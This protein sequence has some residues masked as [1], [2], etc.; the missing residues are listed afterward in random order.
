MVILANGVEMIKFETERLIIRDHVMEDLKEHHR[1][2]SDMEVMSY[3]QDIMTHSL[4]E[5]KENLKFSIM[6]SKQVERK[7]YFFAILEKATEKLVG[8]IGFTILEKGEGT[9]NAE[10]GYFILKEFWGKGYTTEAA[11]AVI[12][13]AFETVQLHK[14]TTGCIAEN[15]GSEHIMIKLGM[16][17]EAH[18]KKHV[19]HNDEWKDRV[20]YG[21]I[22]K[23]T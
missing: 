22:K 4:E 11:K 23:R 13:F 9:G 19:L 17:K 16:E 7:C 14:I 15:V 8:S 10:L 1:L 21:L 20:A 3:I 5:S 6:E 12:D 18:L 2:M